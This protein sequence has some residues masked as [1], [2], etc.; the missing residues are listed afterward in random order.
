MLIESIEHLPDIPELQNRETD[1]S[2]QDEFGRS[3]LHQAAENGHKEIVEMLLA[4][5]ADINATDKYGSTALQYAAGNM[6]MEIFEMLLLAK[7]ADVNASDENRLT[8]L[9]SDELCTIPTSI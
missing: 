2:K 1:V 6:Q 5:G 9:R 3:A 8:A 7:G 4:K